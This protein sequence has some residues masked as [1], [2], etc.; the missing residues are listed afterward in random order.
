MRAWV[1]D[2]ERRTIDNDTFRTVVFT[3]PTPNSR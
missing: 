3:G 1:G 2:I